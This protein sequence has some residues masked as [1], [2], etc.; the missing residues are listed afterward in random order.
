MTLD[1]RIELARRY[2]RYGELESD[3]SLRGALQ[4]AF[5]ELFATPPTHWLAP[6]EPTQEMLARAEGLTDLIMPEPF[7]QTKERRASELEQAY[8]AMRD[9]FLQSR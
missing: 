4:G 5:P 1:E 7:D 6:V 9:A 3:T 2:L 8:F